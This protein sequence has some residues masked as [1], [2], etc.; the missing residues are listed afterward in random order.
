MRTVYVSWM[1]ARIYFLNRI[2]LNANTWWDAEIF[3]FEP[4][5]APILWDAAHRGRSVQLRRSIF[6]FSQPHQLKTVSLHVSTISIYQIW[7]AV[8]IKHHL[9]HYL[10]HFDGKKKQIQSYV[11]RIFG[12]RWGIWRINNS[13][14][15]ILHILDT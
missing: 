12:Y 14:D 1:A 13:D 6:L 5:L 4:P 8:G 2:I 3:L 7:Q 10:C 15:C 9:T 11:Y